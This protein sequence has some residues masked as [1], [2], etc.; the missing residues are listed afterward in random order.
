MVR[1]GSSLCVVF[2]LVL[3]LSCWALAACGAAPP[4]A[5]AASPRAEPF[6]LRQW[7]RSVPAPR[8]PRCVVID[9]ASQWRDERLLLGAVAADL[10]DDWCHFAVERVVVVAAPGPFREAVASAW[11]SEEGV[12]V[13]TL[14]PALDPAAGSAG[15]GIVHAFVVPAQRAQL[16][17]VLR[18]PG[19]DGQVVETTLAVFAGR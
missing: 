9:T 10:A 16:A 4:A 3:L 13:L 12:D 2:R 15:R 17:I 19:A 5:V 14:T 18:A 8:G 6:V 11:H 7:T 1:T